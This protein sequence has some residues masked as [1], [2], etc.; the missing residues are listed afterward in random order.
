MNT[1]IKKIAK[2][3]GVTQDV[4]SYSYVTNEKVFEYVFTET[5][6]TAFAHALI[7]DSEPYAYNHH[8]IYDDD[9]MPEEILSHS[10]EIP[11]VSGMKYASK[12]DELFTHPPSLIAKE[13]EW[14]SVKD[15]VPKKGDMVFG[16]GYWVGEIHGRAK[17]KSIEYGE[18]DNGTIDINGDAYSSELVDISHWLRFELPPIDDEALKGE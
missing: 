17:I 5:Q 14:V 12:T 6:L 13:A 10:K 9:F 16:Y 2:D 18:W 8:F 3:C 7:G 1:T 4:S 11:A 15:S